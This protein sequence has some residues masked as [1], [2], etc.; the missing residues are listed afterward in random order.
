MPRSA[1][2]LLSALL[3]LAACQR[4]DV[5]TYET[6]GRVVTVI[7]ENNTLTVLHEDIPGFMPSMKM[8][9]I[10]RDLTDLERVVA[11]DLIAFEIHV[12][13]DG[14]MAVSGIDKLPAGTALTLREPRP[15]P[16]PVDT[17]RAD[18][19]GVLGDSAL[20][21]EDSTGVR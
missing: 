18:S 13:E 8:D 14:S 16:A 10:P 4:Q 12:A 15:A 1:P 6:R 3:V 2:L 7:P 5:T 21:V 20:V 9:F 11:G 19:L 17:T